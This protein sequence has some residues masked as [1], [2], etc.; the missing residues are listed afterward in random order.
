MRKVRAPTARPLYNDT[1]SDIE[2]RLTELLTEP[3]LHH[4]IPMSTRP[5]SI[6][7]ANTAACWALLAAAFAAWHIGQL[8]LALPLSRCLCPR[9]H[10]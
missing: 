1:D 8:S 2:W 6:T 7:A 3:I 5:N 4:L 10:G 9:C